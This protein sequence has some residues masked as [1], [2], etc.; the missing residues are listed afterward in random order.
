MFYIVKVNYDFGAYTKD[1]V[2]LMV[3]VNF[4]TK[5]DFKTIVGMAYDDFKNGSTSTSES[6]SSSVTSSQA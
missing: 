2:A 3:D 5:D 1:D 6:E 4:I